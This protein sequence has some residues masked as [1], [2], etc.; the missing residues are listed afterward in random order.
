MYVHFDKPLMTTIGRVNLYPA[1]ALMVNDNNKAWP[2]YLG[3]KRTDGSINL[4]APNR[5]TNIFTLYARYLSSR[6]HLATID[7]RLVIK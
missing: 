6:A 7:H 2:R 1:R 3:Y 5:K 4:R